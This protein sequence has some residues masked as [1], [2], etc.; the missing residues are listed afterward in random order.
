MIEMLKKLLRPDGHE[1]ILT[2]QHETARFDLRYGDLVM[3]HLWLDE[4][5]WHFAYTEEFRQQDQVKPLTDFP[6][7]EKQYSSRELWPFFEVRIPSLEQP[8]VQRIIREHHLDEQNQVALL[9]LFGKKSI[10][11]PFILEPAM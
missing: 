6:Y 1:H 4:G 7:L 2:P 3:G 10:A 8:D 9:R 11:N 5:V